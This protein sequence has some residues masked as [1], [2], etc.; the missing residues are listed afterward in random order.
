M[1]KSVLYA[2]FEPKISGESPK[3]YWVKGHQF[4]TL[5]EDG[6]IFEDREEVLKIQNEFKELD[7]Q[8]EEV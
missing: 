8:L 5:K 3:M 6:H 7:L 4:S 2:V 1:K